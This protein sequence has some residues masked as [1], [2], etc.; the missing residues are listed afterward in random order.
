ML[1]L[2]ATPKSLPLIG[3]S[4]ALPLAP[5]NIAYA[6][7]FDVTQMIDETLH[8]LHDNEMPCE[9]RATLGSNPQ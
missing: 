5:I 4:D 3:R 2:L 7:W 1:K 8:V 6:A 9:L